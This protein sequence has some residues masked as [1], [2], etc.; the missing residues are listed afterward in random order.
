PR[1]VSHSAA[2]QRHRT[3]PLHCSLG[4]RTSRRP[5]LGGKRR[6]WSGKYFHS[7]TSG[8]AASMSRILVV[9]DERHLADGLKFNLELESYEIEIVESGEQA[10]DRLRD[11]DHRF[12]LLV[13]D[14]MLPG[15]SGFDV[16]AALREAGELIPTLMLTARSRP[17]D[18]LKGFEA[19]ADD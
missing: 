15:I 18:V 16:M 19:G 12:D 1:S 6:P 3:W 10:L 7:R 14:V 8:G 4:H 9:E 11:K 5:R 2:S 13:L 17:E